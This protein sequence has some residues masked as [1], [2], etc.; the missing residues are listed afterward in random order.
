MARRVTLDLPDDVAEYL[1]SVDNSA[2]AVADA[3]RAHMD[4][5][6]PPTA[7]GRAE[8]PRGPRSRPVLPPMT[9]EQR[10]EIKR[11][12]E[13]VVAGRWPTDGTAA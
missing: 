9:P 8:E 12:Y 10:A 3:V 2:A 13:M 6:A 1:E 5:G 7:R 11:R 4:P